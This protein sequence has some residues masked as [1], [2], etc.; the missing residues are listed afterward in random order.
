MSFVAAAAAAGVAVHHACGFGNAD[1]V[2]LRGAV[3][4]DVDAGAAVRVHVHAFVQ[5]DA[6]AGA[7]NLVGAHIE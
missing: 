2:V 6:D 1:G 5:L 4:A 7:D 3:D